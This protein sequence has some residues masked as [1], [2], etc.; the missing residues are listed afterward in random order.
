MGI[1]V[2]FKDLPWKR[3]QIIVQVGDAN[4]FITLPTPKRLEY[5]EVGNVPMARIQTLSDLHGYQLLTYLGNGW[6]EKN[7]A[8]LDVD[9]GVDSLKETLLKL[10]K[11]RVGILVQTVI[12]VI[13]C[14]NCLMEPY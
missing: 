14:T 5:A 10:A 4:G 7:L 8:D 1:P 6:A 13:F 9:F 12:L 2:Q 3:A 11:K